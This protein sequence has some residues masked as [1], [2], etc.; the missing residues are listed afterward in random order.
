LFT[1]AAMGAI[2][3]LYGFRQAFKYEA[4]P[5]KQRLAAG[6]CLYLVELAGALVLILGSVAGL[7][8]AAVA[9]LLNVAFMIS[10]AWLLVVG[11]YNAKVN[12]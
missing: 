7:Y 4:R 6:S 5:S 3:F 9:I 12:T 11:V 2:S 1:V 10:A 8:M